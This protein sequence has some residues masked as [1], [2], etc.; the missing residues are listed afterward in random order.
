MNQKLRI[1]TEA[2]A[3]APADPSLAERLTFERLLTDLSVRFANVPGDRVETEIERAL[4]E[5]IAFL[6]FDRSTFFEFAADGSMITLC[7]VAIPGVELV[8]VGTA[9]GKELTWYAGELRAD[10]VVLMRSLPDDLPAEAIAE[11]EHVRRVGMRS[12]L[13]IPL[14]VGGRV[15]GALAFGAFR[16]ARVWPDDLIARLRMVGEV[17]AQ[18]IARK[19]ADAELAAAMAEIKRLKDRLEGENAY[20]RDAMHESLP[21]GLASHAPGFKRVLEEVVQVARTSSTVLLQGETGSGKEVVARAIHDQSGRRERPM[22]KVNCAALPANLIE[23]ELFGREKGAYTGALARQMGRFELADGATI[24][25]DEVGELPLE[26]QPKLLRVLQDGEFERVGG[27]RTIKVDARVI[28]ATNRD[29]RACGG[30]GRV[31]QGSLL[32]AERLPD[33]GAAVARAARGHPD[34]RVGVCPGVQ[35]GHGEADRGHRRRFDVGAARVL[36]ARERTRAPQRD[37]ACHD[38]R[39]RLHAAGV[40]HSVVDPRAGRQATRRHPR[41]CRAHASP[42]GAGALRLAHP[43]AEGRRSGARHEAHDARVADE[44]AGVGATGSGLREVVGSP[45]H[46][47]AATSHASRNARATSGPVTRRVPR[48]PSESGRRRGGR[49]RRPRARIAH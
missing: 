24:F 30:G 19:R 48:C 13:T 25:L 38:S 31:P 3:T 47:A 40:A 12:N 16:A 10:R 15:I 7:S 18:A 44:E 21:G 42:A 9:F 2:G 49:V 11:A 45:H 1:A 46:R 33:R 34:A 22:V 41:R 14:S 5:L 6:G 8:P 32:P 35:R 39:A 37:R 20:L 36:M 26:L 4:R 27:T 23:A 43:R 28:A 29:L 17:F